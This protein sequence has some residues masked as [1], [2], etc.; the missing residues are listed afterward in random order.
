VNEC[1][2]CGKTF[3]S[4][5]EADGSTTA[6]RWSPI[7]GTPFCLAGMHFRL[8]T[9]SGGGSGQYAYRQSATGLQIA[10]KRVFESQAASRNTALGADVSPGARSYFIECELIE[11]ASGPGVDG[12]YLAN[13]A[14]GS[15]AGAMTIYAF[16]DCEANG[17]VGYNDMDTGNGDEF[18]WVGGP[19]PY[20][21]GGSGQA[22]F[23]LDTT[24]VGGNGA[25]SQT[26]TVVRT[27]TP[28]TLP[29]HGE[30]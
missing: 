12:G 14:H 16:V 11:A 18:W 17:Q 6:G 25:G 8:L 28:P 15:T 29:Y 21:Q 26:V 1:E 3:G 9:A 13:N 23:Y 24:L 5:W 19:A 20:Y 22:T 7:N 30:L 27:T 10:E 4:L 2:V